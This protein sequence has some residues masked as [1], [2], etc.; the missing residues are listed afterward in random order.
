MI[1]S[2]LMFFLIQW[3]QQPY[4]IETIIVLILQEAEVWRG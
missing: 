4:D 1:Q 3:L 2:F